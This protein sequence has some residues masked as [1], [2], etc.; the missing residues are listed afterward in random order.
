MPRKIPSRAERIRKLDDAMRKIHNSP[1]YNKQRLFLLLN[2]KKNILF[3]REHLDGN[4]KISLEKVSRLRSQIDAAEKALKKI[5]ELKKRSGIPELLSIQLAIADAKNFGRAEGLGEKALKHYRQGWR[6]NDALQKDRGKHSNEKW[7]I[8]LEKKMLSHLLLGSKLAAKAFEMKEERE[9][10]G[11]F[12]GLIQ[13]YRGELKIKKNELKKAL[14]AER[15][16]YE[17]ELKSAGAR[18]EGAKYL[19]IVDKIT[20]ERRRVTITAPAKLV[21]AL[22]R[23]KSARLVLIKYVGNNRKY[24]DEGYLDFLLGELSKNEEMIRRAEKEKQ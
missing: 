10:E 13:R 14:E 5:K 21:D 17:F 7:F 3:L 24:Y 8:L 19:E 6:M 11:M 9:P 22:K 23:E 4:P 20:Y 15:E 12:K 2:K 1:D 16:K 18:L